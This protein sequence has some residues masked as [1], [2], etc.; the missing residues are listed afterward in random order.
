MPV[1][2]AAT[3]SPI[4]FRE[5]RNVCPPTIR[6]PFVDI[7]LTVISELTVNV[8]SVNVDSVPIALEV[9]DSIVE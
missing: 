5:V 6:L 9:K 1:I 2:L 4:T 8:L 3:I 7:E